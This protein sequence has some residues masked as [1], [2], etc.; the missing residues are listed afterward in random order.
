MFY[1]PLGNR[2]EENYVIRKLKLTM[3][4]SKKDAV[5]GR[6][7]A[8][9]PPWQLQNSNPASQGSGNRVPRAPPV[10][11]RDPRHNNA[12]HNGATSRAFQ[13][14]FSPA[15][16][17]VFGASPFSAYSSPFFGSFGSSAFRPS[18]SSLWDASTGNAASSSVP[19]LGALDPLSGECLRET[20]FVRQFTFI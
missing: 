14:P 8:F 17:P 7:R 12:N 10:P 2:F 18:G 4:E 5:S 3:D 6:N 19:R 16:H 11:P 1:L 13:S 15:S 20:G 9:V